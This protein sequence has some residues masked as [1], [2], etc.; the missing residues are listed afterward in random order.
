MDGTTSGLELKGQGSTGELRPP[1]VHL[2]FRGASGIAVVGGS[3]DHNR[4]SKGN[5]QPNKRHAQ[6]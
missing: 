3:E 4:A 6:A 2:R 5:Y 1:G